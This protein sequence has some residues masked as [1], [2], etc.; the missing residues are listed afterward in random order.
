[1][2][3]ARCRHVIKAYFDSQLGLSGSHSPL[4]SL[5]HRL[6]PPGARPVNPSGLREASSRRVKV[7]RSAAE[8]VEVKPT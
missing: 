7:G 5:L 1:M 6:G 2:S 8:I 3:E 4:R